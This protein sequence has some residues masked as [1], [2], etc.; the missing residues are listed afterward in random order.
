M[1]S[2]GPTG[3]LNELITGITLYPF[4]YLMVVQICDIPT[5]LPYFYLFF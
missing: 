4:K 5:R 3:E 1:V 2:K